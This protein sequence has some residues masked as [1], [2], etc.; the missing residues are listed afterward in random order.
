[1]AMNRTLTP[2]IYEARQAELFYKGMDTEPLLYPKIARVVPST[3]A[4]EDWFEISGLGQFRLK[5][6]GTPITYDEPVQGTRRRVTHSTFALGYRVTKE[7]M[8]D[9]QYSV[10]DEHPKDLADAG[11]EHQEIL[12]WDLFNESFSASVHPTIDALALVST[13]HVILKPKSSG[14]AT[15]SNQ[16]SPGVAL[17]VS[18][19]ETA[20]TQMRLTKSREDRFTPITP[21][22]LV[23]HPSNAHFAYQLLDTQKEIQTNENQSSTV[24]TSRTGITAI[25]S[26]YLTDQESWWLLADK[27]KHKLFFHNR[28]D[29]TFDNSTD[30]QTKDSMFDAMYRASV[31]SK[32]WRGIIG[33]Q[34]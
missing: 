19:M 31:A 21:K 5:D 29:M 23:I 25:D 3:K 2:E 32:D 17:S 22:F 9:A 24:S 26:P 28:Q 27:S 34:A 15:A 1:M 20:L 11:R 16:V 12:F 8:A 10:I 33:S 30:S 18:G 4:Y 13:A 14:A 7:A 6:E